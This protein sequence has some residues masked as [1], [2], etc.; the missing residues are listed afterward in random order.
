MNINEILSKCD[1]TLLSVTSTWEEIKA[2]CDDGM[3]FS[4]LSAGESEKA[5]SVDPSKLTK[6]EKQRIVEALSKEM[7]QAAKVLDFETAAK[8]R[9]EIR[10]IQGGK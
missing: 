2:I 10:R 1:H 6:A 9:D 7:A 8:L 3:K 5:K 4:T